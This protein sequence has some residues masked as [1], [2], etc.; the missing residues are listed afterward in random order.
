MK[1]W[2][3]VTGVILVFLL[4]VMAGGIADRMVCWHRVE[5]IIS[6]GPAARRALIIKKLSCELNLNADQ[7]AKLEEIAK[8]THA[9]IKA[10]KTQIQPQVDAIIAASADRVRAMLN[11]EQLEKFNKFMARRKARNKD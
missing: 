4:G 3:A 5:N 9:Q 8:D 10:V 7:K 11:P 6:G 1:K 2:K